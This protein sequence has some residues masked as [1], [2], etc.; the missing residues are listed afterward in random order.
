[1][2]VELNS[3]KRLNG[4]I[5][6]YVIQL[7]VGRGYFGFC[8]DRERREREKNAIGLLRALQRTVSLKVHFLISERY[9]EREYV[10]YSNDDGCRELQSFSLSELL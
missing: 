6:G 2:C 5:L 4:F 9:W 1:M 7:G 8:I 3:T 10:G